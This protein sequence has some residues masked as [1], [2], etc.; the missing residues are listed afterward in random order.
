[1]PFDRHVAE[2]SWLLAHGVVLTADRICSS[3]DM[4]SFRPGCFCGAPLETVG[5]LVFECPLARSVLAWIQPL[6]VLAS[7]L[8]PLCVSVVC[9]L[10][11]IL[12]RSPLW[13]CRRHRVYLSGSWLN[14]FMLFERIY[15]L[16]ISYQVKHVSYYGK[17][18]IAF[19]LARYYRILTNNF[20]L[21]L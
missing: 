18:K 15:A 6:L 19:S 20:R 16:C 12:L 3:F 10:V 9:C 14:V 1:M 8:V 21:T 2:F 11:L 5:H 13:V 4:S 17:L 7:H